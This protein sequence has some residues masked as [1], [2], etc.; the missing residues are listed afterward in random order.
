MLL[1]DDRQTTAILLRLEP[2]KTATAPRAQTIQQ[3]RA[4]A[5]AHDPVA[6]VG[7]E[8]IEI[9]DVFRYVEQD[10]WILGLAVSGLLMVVIFFMFLSPRWMILPLAVVHVTL[11]WTRAGFYFSGVRLSMVSSM[12]TA[13]V[14][15]IGVT[16]VMYFTMS[17]REARLQDDAE[18]ALRKA[19]SRLAIPLFW[20]TFTTAIGFA[21]LLTSRV[22]PVRSFGLMMA[23]GTLLV[24]LACALLL[25]AGTLLW[26]SRNAPTR[27]PLERGIE[28]L[29]HRLA[30][31]ITGAPLMFLL[32]A[33]LIALVAA[34][35]LPQLVVDTDFSKNFRE[36]S[37]IVQ[38]ID[39]FEERF[40][41][42]GNW[43]VYFEAPAELD[44]T[45]LERVEEL[46]KRLEAIQLDDGEKLARVLAMTEPLSFVPPLVGTINQRLRKLDDVQPEVVS[47]FYNP[48][49]KRMR[50]ML[51]A[52][53]RQPAEAKSRLIAEV[54][55]I[56]L[57]IFPDAKITGPFVMLANLINSLM[58]GQ[59]VSLGTCS[60][61]IVLALWVA[62][63]SLRMAVIALI[64]N[65]F[66]VL[67]V[68][69]GM[70]W[71]H[72][73]INVGTAMIASVS[74]GLSVGS[75]VHYLMIYR[76]LRRAGLNHV[77]A[78]AQTHSGVGLALVLSNVARIIGFSILTISAFV[79]LAWFG[80][81]DAL[82]MLGGLV[83]NL[84]LLPVLLYE[85][86]VRERE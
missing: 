22:G 9:H 33:A 27:L 42:V 58:A 6:V 85:R 60:F 10:G 77:I 35:G 57:E 3:I 11:L 73:P 15:I 28:R 81:L 53:E 71:A 69:G 48:Q 63:G 72:V 34:C 26:V 21:S 74:T 23:V 51:R 38:A 1:S 5:A 12:L 37:P 50:I 7:G 4:L 55:R 29:L 25:P 64:P 8:P 32:G 56:S 49:K 24:P 76:R 83:G 67:L 31:Q 46:V 59:M 13:L 45:F 43:E 18:T 17:Y 61:L 19:L 41:G 79:P 54:T 40:G 39:F 70:G 84:V 16:A 36:D 68:L 82:A 75:S 14:T 2:E 30:G 20:S 80:A 66:P 65:V 44:D 78:V 86:P 62:F 47:M 52:R